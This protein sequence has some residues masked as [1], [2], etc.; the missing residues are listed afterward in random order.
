MGVSQIVVPNLFFIPLFSSPPSAC[1]VILDEL[2]AVGNPS[3][4]A[5]LLSILESRG[6]DH[7][8]WL[9]E[10][11]SNDGTEVLYPG[12]LYYLT[13]ECYVIATWT[14]GL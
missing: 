1:V 14:T 3:L 8:L 12:G 2:S 4:L 9:N 11:L 6:S 10:V 13:E 7:T 5:E